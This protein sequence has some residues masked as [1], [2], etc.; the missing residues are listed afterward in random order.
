MSAAGGLRRKPLRQWEWPRKD[1]GDRSYLSAGADRRRGSCR[2]D[3]RDPASGMQLGWLPV[4]GQSALFATAALKSLFA[5]HGPLL[6]FKSDI[7]TAGW[8]GRQGR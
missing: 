2:V 7:H 1:L 8:R 5:D 3:R 6:V 4:L